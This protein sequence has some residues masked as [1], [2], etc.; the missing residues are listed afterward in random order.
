MSKK[1]SGSDDI[2]SVA[3]M[4]LTTESVVVEDSKGN[5]DGPTVNPNIGIYNYIHSRFCY[6]NF[7]EELEGTTNARL[8]YVGLY[9]H[10]FFCS[11]R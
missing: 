3:S 6:R 8:E 9:C 7:F 11:T 4:L 2:A 1:V 5:I 10:W